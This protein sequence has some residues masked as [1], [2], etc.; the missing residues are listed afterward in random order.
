VIKEAGGQLMILSRE[1]R[2]VRR[3]CAESPIEFQPLLPTNREA[4]EFV[5]KRAAGFL[6]AYC[7]RVEDM[8]WIK[9]SFPSK[10]VEFGQLGLPILFVSPR[11]SAVY[12]WCE[13]QSLPYNICPDE[14]VRVTEFTAGLKDPVQWNGLAE[15]I[16]RLAESEFN[17]DLIQ[18]QLVQHLI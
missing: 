10:V 9:S 18:G 14:I 1:T 13:E 8:P 16:R 5:G 17:P 6:A 2:G 11:E 4:L 15:P 7:D 12:A 3:L